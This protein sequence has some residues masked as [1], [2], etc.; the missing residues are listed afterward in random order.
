MSRLNQT[1]QRALKETK[2]PIPL[3]IVRQLD[4]DILSLDNSRKMQNKSLPLPSQA[5]SYS[6]AIK[7][8]DEGVLS[9]ELEEVRSS[10]EKIIQVCLCCR[11]FLNFMV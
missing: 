1:K 7:V 2:N 9:N 4:R 5:K 3:P 6:E 11:A 10:L 8:F